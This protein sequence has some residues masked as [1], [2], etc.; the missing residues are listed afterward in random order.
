[1]ISADELLNKR[2]RFYHKSGFIACENLLFLPNGR[3]GGYD[4]P[5]ER[6]WKIEDGI[7]AIL[8]Q[9]GCV[10]TRFDAVERGGDV[11]IMSGCHRGD[12]SIVLCLAE[13]TSRPRIIGTR[14]HF[15]NQ[16]HG[17]GWEI[18]E[19]TY[20]IPSILEGH[21]AKLRIGRYASI[22]DDVIIGLGNHRADIVSTYPFNELKFYWPTVPDDAK[23]H[24]SKGDVHIGN[25]VWIGTGVFIGSGVTIGDGAVIGAKSV[26]TKGRLEKPSHFGCI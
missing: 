13:N 15:I 14:S 5:N 18:G 6:R 4:H 25:D 23:D 16:I 20:G 19:H 2:W 21:M 24:V 11:V 7:L 1:M 9:D 26:I 22:A 10:T 12:E 17:L 8:D 3:I